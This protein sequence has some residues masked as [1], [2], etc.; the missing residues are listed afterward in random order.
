[1]V[2]K[3]RLDIQN[4]HKWDVN[5]EEAKKI[6]IKLKRYIFLRPLL[7]GIEKIAGADVSYYKDIAIGGVVVLEGYSLKIMESRFYI[8]KVRFPYI[9]GLLTFRE[10]PVL[11]KAFEKIENEPDVII[12]DGQGIAHPR[13]MGIATH[14]GI[15]LDKPS[16]GCA[17]SVLTGKYLSPEMGKGMYTLLKDEGEVIGAALR[18]KEGTN[19][20]FISPGYKIDLMTSIKIALRCCGGYRLPE[21]VRQAHILVNKLKREIEIKKKKL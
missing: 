13:R 10:G 6:Q 14:L 5:P 2:K 15:L 21:P 9:P 1:M 18:T 7:P 17:K 11:L 3:G 16:I 20:V 8:S 19:P 12:F 4:L